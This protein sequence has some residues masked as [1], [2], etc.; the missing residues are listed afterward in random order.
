[1]L[2]TH[3]ER[4]LR[5]FCSVFITQIKQKAKYSMGEIIN[6]VVGTLLLFLE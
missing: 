2:I 1:M 5:H 4:Q 6:A 3:Q